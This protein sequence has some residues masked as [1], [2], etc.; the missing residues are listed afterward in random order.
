MWR[1]V[2]CTPVGISEHFQVH[3]LNLVH[4]PFSVYLREILF[5][6]PSERVFIFWGGAFVSQILPE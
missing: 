3:L 2:W 6:S 4:S 5:I 1:A